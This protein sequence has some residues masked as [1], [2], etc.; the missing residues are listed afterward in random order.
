M[1]KYM[2]APQYLDNIGLHPIDIIDLANDYSP[3]LDTSSLSSD[4]SSTTPLQAAYSAPDLYSGTLDN[5]TSVS[6]APDHAT[7]T[8]LPDDTSGGDG[9][10]GAPRAGILPTLPVNNPPGTGTLPLQD[11]MSGSEDILYYGSV[12]I[13]TPAQS[14]T[15]D[16][17]TG[18]SDLWVPVSCGDCQHNQFDPSQSSTFH[19]SGKIFSVAYVRT[20]AT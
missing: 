4:P 7:G 20:H 15:V 1:S 6:G 19:G 16:I 18:S 8:S 3:A 9:D 14:L 13:G 2:K 11:Y 5:F 17:D 10:M 12:D